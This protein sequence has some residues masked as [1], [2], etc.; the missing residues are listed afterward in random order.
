MSSYII[1]VKNTSD[2]EGTIIA[3]VGF[4]YT[5]KLSEINEANIKISGSSEIKRSLIEIGSVVKI[6]RGGTLE[7][8]GVVDNVDYFGGGAIAIH[9]SGY[10]KWLALENG[11]YASSP[12]SATASATIASAVIAE[13][14][15]FTIGTNNTGTSVDFRAEITDSLYNVLKNLTKA[16]QQDVGIDYANSEVDILDHKGS[17]TSVATLNA[18]IQ[19]GDLRVSQSYP[20]GNKILVY[21]KSE[22]ET[23]IKSEY[24]GHGYN[25][26]SQ[27]SYG[28]ITKIIRDSKITTVA[29]ANIVA[30]AEVARYK[31]PIKIYD[32]DVLNPSQSLVCG[33]VI[34]LNA[35]SQEISNEEVRIVRLDKGV[36]GGEEFL[37]LQ[38]TNVEYSKIIKSTNEQIA[39]VEKEIRDN[40]T[41]DS[42][43]AEYSN[44][45]CSTCIGGNSYVC[46]DG[47]WSFAEKIYYDGSVTCLCDI[48][49]VCYGNNY[50]KFNSGMTVC[51]P[52]FQAGG[53]AGVSTTR[54]IFS[55]GI[56]MCGACLYNLG[57]GAG[58]NMWAD[59]TNPY[60]CPCNSC[61]VCIGTKLKIPVGTNCY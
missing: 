22:G 37:T 7:F 50:F 61:G 38:V 14:N 26:A 11:A 40:Q 8:H 33:D 42:Y 39:E 34:T 45:N 32:F 25:E 57:G 24:P 49:A 10:E 55:C 29:Q 15:Y 1:N 31:D 52:Q 58:S 19:M 2:D 36:K 59:T 17:A 53:H 28:V 43:Q 3:D 44:A 56:D 35:P 4:S 41:Y 23:R 46:S 48:F 5:D 6:Y 21:G 20:I 12:W 16:T 30:D 54:S 51:A 27:T 47:T 9:S 18:G 13:S 60:I